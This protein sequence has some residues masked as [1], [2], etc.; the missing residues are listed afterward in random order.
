MFWHRFRKHIHDV[1]GMFNSVVDDWRVWLYILI[2]AAM[3]GGRFYYSW[4]HEVPEW[5]L[6]LPFVVFSSLIALLIWAS[7][8]IITL[9]HEG[10]VLFMLQRKRWIQ[11]ILL[12]G[13]L[14]SMFTLI[15]KVCLY[16]VI[17]LPFLVQ[18]FEMDT[19]SVLCFLL[20]SITFAWVVSWLKH[21]VRIRSKGWRRYLWSIPFIWLPITIY[22]RLSSIWYKDSVILVESAMIMALLSGILLLIRLRMKGTLIS[23]IQEDLV[24]RTVLT[25]LVLSQ[26]MDK[27]RSTRSK[28][29]LMR[30]SQSIF[31]SRKPMKRLADAAIKS[32]LRQT[33][34]VLLY[35]QFM[36][37]CVVTLIAV[38]STI[39]WAVLLAMT[40]LLTYSLFLHWLRFIDNEFV[41]MLPWSDD[42]TPHAGVYTVR[43]LLLPFAFI[44]SI[45]WLCSLFPIWLGILLSIPCAVVLTWLGVYLLRTMMLRRN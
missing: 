25:N 15:I 42:E 20:F 2:P 21:L 36:M 29:I 34:Q 10:D 1:T 44:G 8:S 40:A 9:L 27:P 38:P 32:L 37:I 19:Q 5:S 33:N 31:R 41:S 22:V 45:T 18:R 7:G 13:S 4:W 26:V 12:G 43:A 30:R 28:P 16:I 14:Y 23:D 11:G 35:L 3:I 24:Q 17:I 39:Q 6:A